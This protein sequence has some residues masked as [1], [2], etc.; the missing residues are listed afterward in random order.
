MGLT[1]EQRLAVEA[2]GGTL[3]VSA[4]A[5]SGKTT[6][7]VERLLARISDPGDPKNV[8]DFLLITFTRAA[9]GEMRQRILRELHN[10]LREA[11]DDR[12]LRRQTI[13]V[14]SAQ[15]STLHAYC[16][17]LV[18]QYAA[19]CGIHP[20]A[21]LIADTERDTLRARVLEDTLEELYA[22]QPAD[23]PFFALAEALA[24]MRGDV[25]LQEQILSVHEKI[26]SHP[27]PLGWL[28]EHLA[29]YDMPEGAD[30]GDTV[31]GRVILAHARR[32]YTYLS[33]EL[34][35]AVCDAEADEKLA[36]AYA[37][38][39][40]TALEA[41]RALLAA[42]EA[43]WDS[44]CPLLQ[45]PPSVRLTGVRG[46]D[47][48][49]TGPLKKALEAWREANKKYAGI[50]E[51]SSALLREEVR[52]TRPMLAGLALA[53][54]AFDEA[55][56]REKRRL[57]ALDYGDL[58]HLAASLLVTRDAS[59]AF[60]PTEIARDEAQRFAEVFVD[61]YQDI[62]PMQELLI[63]ALT[64]GNL[65]MVGDVR[66]SIY[67]F[68]LAEPRYFLEKYER[69]PEAASARD[70]KT[71][72]KA[73]LT[74]NFRS[75]PEILEAV[76][77]VFSRTMSKEAGEL[78][79]TEAEYVRPGLLPEERARVG[80]G[81]VE[82]LLCE[83][84]RA[85]GG[86]ESVE[87]GAREAAAAARRLRALMDEGFPVSD[88]RGGTRPVT[89]GDMAVL[90]RSPGPRVSVYRRALEREGLPV[91]TE[92]G[93]GASFF[94]APEIQAAVA[95]LQ[96]I[97]NPLQE[98][99]LLAAL[100]CPA[101][102][103]TGDELAALRI[104]CP[105]GSFY[106]AVWL[107]AGQGQEACARLL[108]DLDALRGLAPD[109][110]AARL[111]RRLYA[112]TELLV[113]YGGL[114]DGKT[115]QERLRLLE[116]LAQGLPS[117]A[118]LL[119]ALAR[120]RESGQEPR[121]P[122]A[123]AGTAAVRILSVHKSKGLEFPV[124]VAADLSK[125][126]NR[127]SESEWLQMHPEM[128]FGL[129]LQSWEASTRTDTLPHRAVALKL[130][131]EALAE[132][133]RILYV[134]MTRAREKLILSCAPPRADDVLAL[135]KKQRGSV[136]IPPAVVLGANSL[137]DWICRSVGENWIVR[138]E[139]DI[140]VGDETDVPPPET[141]EGPPPAAAD[142][143]KLR[144]RL[145]WV[146]PY[147]AA[148]E[149]P[150]KLTVTGLKG[151][152]L[153]EEVHERGA[154]SGEDSAGLLASFF[155]IPAGDGKGLSAAARGS[156]Q[157]LAMQH[158]DL[159]LCREED[160][161]RSEVARLLARRLL[162][163]EQA[164]AVDAAAVAALMR[165]AYGQRMLR[166]RSLHRE[167]KFSLLWDIEE[168]TG[169]PAQGEET[170]FQGV[171]DCWWEEAQGLVLLDF[172]T[173]R[174]TSGGEVARAEAYRRQLTLYARALTRILGKPVAEKA[175][176]FFATGKAAVL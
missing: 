164:A 132:E 46:A 102:G 135:I 120:L 113:H 63:Q 49:V 34:A 84:P 161:V 32:E 59:G 1:D 58:E 162:S 8:D 69:Y 51:G 122:E 170:L 36:K 154:Q 42:M 30:A 27:E 127:R 10:R 149:L 158:L 163:E 124:V 82:L 153:D 156:A 4:A 73:L 137:A 86:E 115:R 9:A 77:H 29:R 139:R 45:A 54:E 13:R 33:G 72:R 83:S 79:Y 150:S 66:Q 143:E 3:L 114:R 43:N 151:R 41:S 40:R 74:R 96:L 117:A 144:E 168:L 68:R 129:R 5:G 28:R 2:R 121:T 125:P 146:Y 111:L 119:A 6:V 75:K 92:S 107:A 141:D 98:V 157:H 67:R 108:G 104:G 123:G 131:Q 130:R 25:P 78:A 81:A 60:V 35:A 109:L 138:E 12:H 48:A 50:L 110:D 133:M 71:P 62:S 103:L 26:Q 136:V 17:T 90:L 169:E 7:L 24:G 167:F 57:R 19:L 145:R 126:F 15:I 99:P 152:Y 175:V 56:T 23:S 106:E 87:T 61:E 105:E 85:R 52:R 11:P 65:F 76:N 171:I 31:W 140:R 112:R 38:A 44:A 37:P 16:Q 160:G 64:R 118:D 53:V 148:T 100:R 142:V 21:R 173:D 97:D 22:A 80:A 18:R 89:P 101:Y 20:D 134:A 155:R 165:G 91:W 172:K 116:N 55:L 70:G 88:G 128:G 174:L 93:G 47:E 176:Y 166:A 14:H 39:L 95:L 159:S 147:A 94:A